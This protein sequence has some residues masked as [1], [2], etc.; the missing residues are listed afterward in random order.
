ME[1]VQPVSHYGVHRDSDAILHLMQAPGRSGNFIGL[2]T[3]SPFKVQTDSSRSCPHLI[4]FSEP[5]VSKGDWRRFQELLSDPLV[6]QMLPLPREDGE[7]VRFFNDPALE[8]LFPLIALSRLCSPVSQVVFPIATLNPRQLSE[9]LSLTNIC[10]L[11]LI[12]VKPEHQMLIER[13]AG[14]SMFLPRRL[15]LLGEST[16]VA[17]GYI[18][19]ETTKI[20]GS[21]N[22]LPMENLGALILRQYARGEP[23]G[24]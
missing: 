12:G 5:G 23:I 8:L 21:L 19:R 4:S 16:V 20:R 24:K 9:E 22:S 13:T 11:V 17:A 7:V 14:N 15:V 3:A 6:K 10:P 2:P 18:K 1:T